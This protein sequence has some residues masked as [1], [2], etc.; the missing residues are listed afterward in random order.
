MQPILMYHKISPDFEWGLTTIHP[1]IFEK[2][3]SFLAKHGY[4]GTT[5]HQLLTNPHPKQ[6]AISFDDAYENV[7]EYALPILQKYGFTATFFVIGDYIGKM[8]DWDVNIGGI[9]F[10]HMSESQ[11]IS[12]LENGWELGSHGMSHQAFIR[13]NPTVLDY[14]LTGSKKM[15]E[16]RFHTIVSLI[17]FPFGYYNYQILKRCHDAG[18][19]AAIAFSDHSPV[20]GYINVYGRMG[21]YR[22][23]DSVRDVLA[24]I[25]AKN[26]FFHYYQQKKGNLVHSGANLTILYQLLFKR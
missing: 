16:E 25:S 17:A 26:S 5:I 15:L 11:I 14:E 18:Y 22:W 20:P 9:H 1:I 24:K 7:Y 10:R 2:Q 23:I 6:F 19:T 21:V 4:Q 3:I 12:L 13:K 8:N